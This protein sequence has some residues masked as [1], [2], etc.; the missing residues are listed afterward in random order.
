MPTGIFNAHINACMNRMP[1]QPNSTAS[2]LAGDYLLFQINGQAM[3]RAL[4]RLRS[5]VITSRNVTRSVTGTNTPRNSRSQMTRHSVRERDLQCRVTGTVV[6]MR[7]RRP[8]FKGMQVAHIYPLG[9]MNKARSILTSATRQSL[10]KGDIPENAILMRAD[11]HDQFDNY[12][13]GFWPD[14]GVFRFYRFE[15]SG[16]PTIVQGSTVPMYPR[17]G[18][19]TTAEPIAEL[20]RTHFITALLWHVAGFGRSMGR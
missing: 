7:E 2:L 20:L 6:P 12:Q 16:A 17:L 5:P 13:F 10:G 9:H 1:E 11:A 3:E 8:N 19:I 14:H 4:P 18:T 15:R